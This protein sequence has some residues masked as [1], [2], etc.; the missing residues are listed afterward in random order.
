M[1]FR[2]CVPKDMEKFVRKCGEKVL[3]GAFFPRLVS[4]GTKCTVSEATTGLLH[5][6]QMMMDDN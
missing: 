1:I 5:Q 4:S 2:I 6:P 3:A